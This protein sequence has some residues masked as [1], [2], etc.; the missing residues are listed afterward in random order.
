M[1]VK[2]KKKALTVEE[3]SKAQSQMFG[4]NKLFKKDIKIANVWTCLKNPE[5]L[6][7][8][9]LDYRNVLLNHFIPH[10]NNKLLHD[11]LK[12]LI[13]KTSIPC[14]EQFITCFCGIQKG[15]SLLGV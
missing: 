6:N 3:L 2:K 4:F 12:N 15:S 1:G 9:V 14:I 13:I 5:Q 7:I 8:F 10:V 11:D